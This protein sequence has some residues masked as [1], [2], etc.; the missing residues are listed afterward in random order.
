MYIENETFTPLQNL[1]VIDLSSNSLDTVPRELLSL[2]NLRKLYMNN[3][4]LAAY[5]GLLNPPSSETLEFLSLS[6]C[7]LTQFPP[8]DSFPSLK[9]VNF[10]TNELKSLSTLQLAPMCALQSLDLSNNPLLFKD[11]RQYNICD[12]I[13]VELWIESKQIE[14]NH[15]KLNCSKSK[16]SYYA[17]VNLFLF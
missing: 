5:A 3:N 11:R 12:C 4:R 17:Q 15:L 8:L 10:S 16:Y 6:R 9:T 1:E 2:P 7:H 14:M 13:A